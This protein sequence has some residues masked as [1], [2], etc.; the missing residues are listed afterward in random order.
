VKA[1]AQPLNLTMLFLGDIQDP[2][3]N[4]K[5]IVGEHGCHFAANDDVCVVCDLQ[6]SVNRVIGYRNQ[7]HIAGLCPTIDVLRRAVGLFNGH[8]DETVTDWFGKG[9]VSVGIE[10][11]AASFKLAGIAFCPGA[12]RPGQLDRATGTQGRFSPSK[13]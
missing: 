2:K 7:I 5:A 12:R 4:G 13:I 8:T 11:Q 10:S 3:V 9:S 6:C 1:V